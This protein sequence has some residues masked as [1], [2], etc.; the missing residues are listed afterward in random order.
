MIAKR[1]K[2]SIKNEKNRRLAFCGA[3]S[4]RR[5]RCCNM[6]MAVK[7]KRHSHIHPHRNE[8]MASSKSHQRTFQSILTALSDAG[9]SMRLHTRTLAKKYQRRQSDSVVFN[10]QVLLP[11]D[12]V[13][14]KVKLIASFADFA[15]S[16]EQNCTFFFLHRPTLASFV[17]SLDRWKSIEREN[18]ELE[19]NKNYDHCICNLF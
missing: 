9:D 16:I 19:K 17:C 2:E 12:Q 5:L 14:R 1:R 15:C 18:R 3:N 6:P 8:S 13:K 11:R 7:I 10:H 4:E